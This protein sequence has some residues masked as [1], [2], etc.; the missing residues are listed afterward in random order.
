[1]L[2]QHKSSSIEMQGCI[3]DV[4]KGL[5]GK[6]SKSLARSSIRCCRRIP[7]TVLTDYYD[8]KTITTNIGIEAKRDLD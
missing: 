1:M 7:I 8:V 5:R 3:H 6:T 4:S 2:R